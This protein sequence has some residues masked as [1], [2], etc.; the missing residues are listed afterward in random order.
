MSRLRIP[1]T[2]LATAALGT[3]QAQP[4][5]FVMSARRKAASGSYLLTPSLA[6]LAQSSADLRFPLEPLA[7]LEPLPFPASAEQP[8]VSR[9][10]PLVWSQVLERL[11]GLAL[12]AAH[13]G[14]SRL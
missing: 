11:A 2:L 1:F 4:A 13:L 3:V 14:I 12:E 5:I 7:P 9:L 6:V 10:I 8:S